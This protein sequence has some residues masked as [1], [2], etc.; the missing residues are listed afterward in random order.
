MFILAPAFKIH[1]K[2]QL[3]EKTHSIQ[4]E[5]EKL[6]YL[7][8]L[9]EYCDDSKSLQVSSYDRSGGNNDG[10]AGT[11]SYIRRNADSTLV[12][13]DGE[14]RGIIN[15]IWTPTPTDDTLDFYFG[16]TTRVS[17]SIRFSD[18]FSGDVFPF[19]QPLCGNEIGGYYSYFPIPYENGCRIVFRG[20][21]M[22]FIQIQY[23]EI[24]DRSPV[25]VFSL[26]LSD[27]EKKALE[28]VASVWNGERILISSG[29]LLKK[30]TDVVLTPGTA[31]TI[32]SA[33]KGGRIMG[34]EIDHAGLF[35]GTENLVDIKISYDNEKLPAI[36]TPLADLFGYSFGATSMQSIVAGTKN[37]VNYLYLPMPFDSK[38]TVEL[39][40][41]EGGSDKALRF[42][43]C[44][45]YS[46]RKR[47]KKSEGKLY[48]DW[49]RVL[50]SKEGE[51]LNMANV[52]GKGHYVGTVMQTQN[53]VP[54]MTLFFEGDDI[55]VV[56]GENTIHGTG[57]EDY[58][59]GGWYA[60]LDTWDRAISLP[61]HG[62]LVYSLAYGR[63]GAYRWHLTDKICFRRSLD[64]TM[65]HGPDGNREPVTNT[66][67]GF[68]YSD[69]PKQD[70]TEPTNALSEVYIPETF[71]L[72]PQTM[73]LN[74]W[75]DVEMKTEWC[76]PSGG[77]TYIFQG[78]DESKIRVFLDE[79]PSG[80][81]KLYLDYKKIPEG[82]CVSFWQRQHQISEAIN[83]FALEKA[84]N[85]KLYVCDIEVDAT[86]NT[87]TFQFST[88]EGRDKFSL[89]RLIFEKME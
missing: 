78:S 38:A 79:I 10:F 5:L 86:L 8:H 19:I 4:S 89:N 26:N 28:E 56:D 37:Q 62:S 9:P 22:R 33:E 39:I 23:R 13:F 61:I 64:Y 60:F 27:S 36:Y 44:V 47:D 88:E 54:G 34:I 12:I 14:G 71:M 25:K 43:T 42:N 2:G 51:P 73:K 70:L 53:L 82:C 55:A 49:N 15:R 41:R 69:T 24:T 20:D 66:T 21:V 3:T 65:E 76:S 7:D 35:E 6:G 29:D 50:E 81:Y 58:F 77:Y 46:N 52:K 85:E 45:Y 1:T 75:V 16:D 11:Y 74:L 32:F 68:Y 17:F 57:S 83:T 59:N 80:K 87:L 31:K 84:R 48:V 40:Y 63:T 30:E 67:L 72:Y 18:L